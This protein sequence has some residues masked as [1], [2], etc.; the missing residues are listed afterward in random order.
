MNS[1]N[2]LILK[3]TGIIYIRLI[4][5]T[6]IGLLSSRYVLAILGASDYGLFSVVGG[7][8]A[9]LNVLSTAMYTTTRRYINVEMGKDDGNLN[10]VFNISRLL[11]IGF[12]I[13]IFVIAETIGLFYIYNYLNVAPGKLNDALYVFQW[14]TFAAAVGI[15]NVPY[16]ALL[17]AYEKFYQI[18]I[19][20]VVRS[21]M[22]FLFVIFL[23]Y[24]DGYVLRIFA[25][26]TGLLTILS[27]LLYNFACYKQCGSVVKYRFYRDFSLYKEILFFNNYVAL[28][29][30][31]YI[32]RVQGA[33]LIV[34]FFFGTIVN[35][36]FAVGN[37]IESYCTMI[38]SNLG[39]AAAPQI[40]QNYEGDN[41]RSLF[42]T[43]SLHRISIMLSLLFVVPLSME[44]EFILNLWLKNPPDGSYIICHLMLISL[45][46][47]SV[48]G[49]TSDLIQASGKIKWFQIVSSIL[50]LSCLPIS[51]VLYYRGYP[52][53]III[54]VNI[55]IC[56]IDRIITFYM[57][58]SI[59][60]F[61]VLN[62]VKHVYAR[63]FVIIVLSVSVVLLYR[64]L[65]INGVFFHLLGIMMGGLIVLLLIFT[66]GMKESE[67]D[68]VLVKLKK[69]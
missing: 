66:V 34:N 51:Y 19:I 64:N 16:Q 29:A 6:I 11:H 8:I 45:L 59:L 1:N 15:V 53:Y 18:A 47:K 38:V 63:S 42:L 9:M 26:G 5:T 60:S 58:K 65:I 46:V 14:A 39:S 28:G 10:K 41:K 30:A 17:M 3:N 2:R 61:N 25:A 67:R 50:L 57:M 13:L 12:A 32:G 68:M 20:D 55:V 56:F 43:E 4:I 27:L 69:K 54:V 22:S 44:L 62:Y 37:A 36:A 21:V 31:A 7:L 33:N 23:L 52:A 24:Y 35:A 40:T 49:G 48:T